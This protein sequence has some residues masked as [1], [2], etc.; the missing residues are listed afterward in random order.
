MWLRA[1]RV[2][3]ILR[4]CQPL[5]LYRTNPTSLTHRVHDRN[6]RAE[7]VTRALRQWGYQSPDGARARKAEV[8]FVLARSWAEYGAQLLQ[9]GSAPA[10]GRAAARALR[11]D[12]T[13]TQGWI[14]LGKALTHSLSLSGR[15]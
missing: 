9:A 14:V 4:V 15:S 5:A 2:T 8:R 12:P 7:V 13:Y 3:P 1:S 6:Y 11:L 10:A